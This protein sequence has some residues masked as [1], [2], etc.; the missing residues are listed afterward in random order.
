MT[1]DKAV[2]DRS[3]LAGLVFE[4]A[5]QLHIE[6]ALRLA[7]QAALEKAGFV[8]SASLQALASD[9]ALQR[10]SR[11][12]LEESIAKLIRV[13]TENADPRRPLRDDEGSNKTEGAKS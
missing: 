7:L 9:P 1:G 10:R 11:E 8:D 2:P 6:R 4:L 3:Q 13:L 5:S 12:A